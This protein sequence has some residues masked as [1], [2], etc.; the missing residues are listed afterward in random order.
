MPLLSS[1]LRHASASRDIELISRRAPTRPRDLARA[2]YRPL[3][4]RLATAKAPRR[5]TCAH[6]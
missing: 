5:H 6:E 3:R 2:G 4:D 1:R